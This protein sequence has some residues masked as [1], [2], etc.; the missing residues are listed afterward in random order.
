MEMFILC[1]YA[2]LREDTA[3]ETRSVSANMFVSSLVCSW[4]SFCSLAF[5]VRVN[6]SVCLDGG[7]VFISLIALE[8]NFTLV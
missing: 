5:G 7:G 6:L 8:I 4:E 1:P 3:N 2:F